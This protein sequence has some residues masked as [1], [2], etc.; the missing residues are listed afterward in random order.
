MLLRLPAVHTG[1]GSWGSDAN[2]RRKGS[3]LRSPAHGLDNQMTG[4]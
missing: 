1:V 2:G 3:A 4:T